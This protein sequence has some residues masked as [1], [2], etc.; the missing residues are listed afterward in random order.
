MS[1]MSDEEFRIKK[2]LLEFQQIAE[3]GLLIMDLANATIASGLA[4]VDQMFSD[5]YAEMDE[6][7]WEIASHYDNGWEIV[8]GMRNEV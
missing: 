7:F 3:D 1:D 4:K 8:R 6:A 2:F 5:L